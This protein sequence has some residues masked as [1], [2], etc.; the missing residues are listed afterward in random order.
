MMPNAITQNASYAGMHALRLTERAFDVVFQPAANPWR[1]LGALSFFFFW[2]ATASGIYLYI[3]FDTSVEGAYRSV[4]RLTHGQWYA[5]GV[6]RSL[7]RYASDALVVSVVLHLVKELAAGRFAGFRWFSWV[8]GVPLLWLLLASGIVGY[9][10]VWDELA[11]FV[12]LATAEWFDALPLFAEPLVRN[13]LTP[14][15]V[16]D[17]LFTLLVFLHIGLPLALLA[18]MFI[19][20]QRVNYADVVPGR[21]L[22]WS[23]FLALAALSLARPA[24]SEGPADLTLVPQALA[25]DWFYLAFYPLIYEWSPR[26]AWVLAA[27]ATAA[28]LALPLAVRRPRAP[29]ARVDLANCNGCGRCF[30]DC[31]YAAVVMRPRHGGRPGQQHA[32]VIPGLCASCGICT[33]A[34]PSST[35][36][37]SSEPLATGIDMPQQPIDAVR[38]ELERALLTLAQ[39]GDVPNPHPRPTPAEAGE[40]RFVA[41][42]GC[43]LIAQ[44][45]TRRVVV[46]GCDHGAAV[47][48]CKSRDVATFGLLCI[49]MLP[50]AFIEY[51]LRN[52]ADGVLVA[53]CRAGECEYRL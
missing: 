6:M 15:G 28:L 41:Q 8:S 42:A 48:V 29:V 13:F 4:D 21:V 52:G 10:L 5:G 53:A 27:A 33:G 3:F 12:A 37:R 45:S 18:G 11:Q 50:P 25:L 38:Q 34:C 1:H 46:Y 43:H 14:E 22:G 20:V 16:S 36:F 17:R 49:G 32:L 51:A 24:T 30:A 2:I 19:H 35:P 44:G 40:G 7:H 9:W 39:E 47:A 23:T 26:A 31:P